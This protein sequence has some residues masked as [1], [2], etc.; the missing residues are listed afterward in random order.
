MKWGP[1]MNV[2]RHLRY[3]T[4]KWTAIS[5]NKWG[6]GNWGSSPGNHKITASLP[7]V[8]IQ[9]HCWL[10]FQNCFVHAT[11]ITYLLV[12]TPKKKDVCVA[13]HASSYRISC[14]FNYLTIYVNVESPK[15]SGWDTSQPK[16]CLPL[17]SEGWKIE[18]KCWNEIKYISTD[19]ITDTL[20]LV[21]CQSY[22]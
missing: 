6:W 13:G 14:S 11:D 22:R 2:S 1:V 3:S 7:G 17:I 4:L 19:S 20:C 16:R 21:P 5:F 10:V 12:K 18:S 8:H 15:R 9:N